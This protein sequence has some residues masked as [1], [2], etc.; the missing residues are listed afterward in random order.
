[1]AFMNFGVQLHLKIVSAYINHL[2]KVIPAVA[3]REGR[4]SGHDKTHFT[5][6]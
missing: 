2:H 5:V 4:A 3:E 6:Y 1:M